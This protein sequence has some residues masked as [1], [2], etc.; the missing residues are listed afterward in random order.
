[1]N[2]QPRAAAAGGL[3]R[4]QKN[5][6]HPYLVARRRACFRS[7]SSHVKGNGE[8]EQEQV[9]TQRFPLVPGTIP[10]TKNGMPKAESESLDLNLWI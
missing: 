3:R 7:F 4:S 10:G 6:E 8:R 1:M 9:G 5:F 2:E